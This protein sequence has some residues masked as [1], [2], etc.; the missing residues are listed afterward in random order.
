[1][2]RYRD[3]AVPDPS[4]SQDKLLELLRGYPQETIDACLEFQR[5]R[6]ERAFEQTFAGIIERHLVKPPAQPVAQLPGSTAIVAGLGID[7]LTMVEMAF[8]FE[9]LF[10]T[11]LP[12]EEFSKIVTLDDLRSM[13]RAKLNLPTPA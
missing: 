5:T 3:L 11:Q 1:M 6:G 10:A 7:S 4:P 12:H 8:L 9:D 13:L 2:A